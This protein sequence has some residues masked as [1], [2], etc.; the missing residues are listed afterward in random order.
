MSKEIDKC[1]KT[2]NFNEN[3]IP[4]FAFAIRTD[5]KNSISDKD[6]LWTLVGSC[7]NNLNRM[8]KETR[9]ECLSVLKL[10]LGKKYKK[11]IEKMIDEVKTM[12]KEVDNYSESK[13]IEDQHY[14]NTKY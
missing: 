1:L 4:I 9:I 6:Y 7:S 10:S 3:E 12:P 5:T 11:D 13:Q 8:S 14:E 2:F